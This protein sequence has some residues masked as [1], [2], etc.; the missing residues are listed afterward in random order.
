M[1]FCA[2]SSEC[3]LRY[4]TYSVK[5]KLYCNKLLL[6]VDSVVFFAC[7]YLKSKLILTL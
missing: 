5:E 2:L 7:E 4:V 1:S 6:L 3:T